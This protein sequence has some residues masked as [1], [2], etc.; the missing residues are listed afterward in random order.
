MRFRLKIDNRI[1]CRKRKFREM[2]INIGRTMPC[3]F[4]FRQSHFRETT[5]GRKSVS[6]ILPDTGK[7]IIKSP[8]SRGITKRKTAEN[9]IKRTVLEHAASDGDRSYFQL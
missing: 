9:G 2:D 3:L 7:E 1:L 8:N 5:I 6:A 4:S